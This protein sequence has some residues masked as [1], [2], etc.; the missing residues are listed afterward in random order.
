MDLITSMSIFKRVVEAGSFSAVARETG[1]SQPTVSKH[2]AELENRL[3]T[4]LLNR[5]TRQL[6]LTEAGKEYYDRCS[7]ILS[8][9]EQ[10]ESSVGQC[11]SEPTGTLRINVPVTF[12]RMY[13]LPI[14]WEFMNQ[15][16]DLK[17]DLVM[18]DGYIDLVKDGVDLAIRVGPLPDSS[19]IARKIGD[20]PRVTVVSP[21]YLAE[22]GEP[23]TL[24]DLKEHSCIVYTFLTTRNEWHFKG[25]EGEEKL[26]VYGRFSA[27]NPDA[28]RDAV[29]A[30]IGIAVTPL[31]LIHDALTQGKVKVILTDYSP[32]PL[33]VHA[34]YPDRRFVPSRVGLFINYLKASMKL[35]D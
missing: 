1:L 28:I 20:S 22:H 32:T 23:K 4:K 10:L 7:L 26:R 15:Y 14:L 8:D 21:D 6:S 13:L 3:D 27:S 11:R 2:I 16:P 24:S 34:V 12:G 5:S 25:S 29:I 17:L 33:E 19:L 30:G 9:L 18:D 35:P 31:W